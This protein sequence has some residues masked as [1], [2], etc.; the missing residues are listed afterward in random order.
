MIRTSKN[1]KPNRARKY[2]TTIYRELNIARRPQR[3]TKAVL[4]SNGQIYSSA[5]GV[6]SGYISMDPSTSA[7]WSGWA[8]IYD[9]FR[10]LGG[11]L[12]LSCAVTVGN[13]TTI[14]GLVAFAFDNDSA[15][16]PANYG[17]IIQFAE[18]KDVTSVWTGGTIIQFP[19]KRPVR[20]GTPQEFQLWYNESSPSA[21][22]GSIKYYGSGMS[23]STLYMNY[24]VEYLVEFQ[25]RT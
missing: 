12:K 9:Q 10:V 24:L 15:A 3:V 22:P 18:V 7:E 14:P 19:F 20:N 1:R 17:Q 23:N 5:G 4:A 11:N 8:A 6:I 2:E 25:M 16:T 21:S 13:S